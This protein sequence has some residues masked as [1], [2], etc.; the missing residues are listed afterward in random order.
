[1]RF[2]FL[3]EMNVIAPVFGNVMPVVWKILWNFNLTNLWRNGLSMLNTG[4]HYTVAVQNHIKQK[5]NVLQNVL[6]VIKIY[7]YFII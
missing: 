6:Y 7:L 2:E 3:M 5:F 4:I 1:M